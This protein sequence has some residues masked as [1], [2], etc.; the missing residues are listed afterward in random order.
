MFF[1]LFFSLQNRALGLL[2]GSL[3]ATTT[4]S[5]TGSLAGLA[6]HA[7]NVIKGTFDIDTGLGRSLCEFAAESLGHQ[8]TLVSGHLA[9]S[10]FVAFVADQHQWYV[11]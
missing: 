4:L 9:L 1:F 11:F 6:D 5:I 2:L 10:Q 7:D 3:V 8:S